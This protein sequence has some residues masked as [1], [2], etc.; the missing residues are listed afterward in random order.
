MKIAREL[1][2]SHEGGG[3]YILDEPTTGLHVKDVEVLIGVLRELVD[4]GNTVAVI[5]HNPQVILQADY[6]IDLGPGGGQ[7]G[8]TVVAAGTPDRIMR[9]R[10]SR[11]GAYLRKLLKK[12][13]GTP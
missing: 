6:I 9:T 1:A 3:F 5:E 7:D 11:T 4:R 10:G 8:G 2:E 13:K 12:K